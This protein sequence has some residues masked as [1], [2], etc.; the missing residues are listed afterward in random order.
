M[1]ITQALLMNTLQCLILSIF[2]YKVLGLRERFK[3]FHVLSF[4]A[5]ITLLTYFSFLYYGEVRWGP[6]HGFLILLLM[7]FIFYKGKIG[8]K[9]LFLLLGAILQFFVE[10]MLMLLDEIASIF[11]YIGDIY[12]WVLQTLYCFVLLAYVFADKKIRK[13]VLLRHHMILVLIICIITVL[14]VITGMIYDEGAVHILVYELLLYIIWGVVMTL[15]YFQGKYFAKESEMITL[16][17]QTKMDEQYE[18]DRER[19]NEMIRVL[20]HDLKHHLQI[21]KLKSEEAGDQETIKDIELYSGYLKKYDLI[22]VNNK[23]ANAIIN[24][25]HYECLKEQ[26]TFTV[27]GNFYDDLELSKM[28]LTALL[29]NLL[30]NAFEAALK[31]KEP[32]LRKIDLSINRDKHFLIIKLENGC[33]EKPKSENG[34]YI[35]GKPDKIKHGLGIISIEQVIN[36]YNGLI[37]SNYHDGLFC[38]SI[39]FRA[40]TA[41]EGDKES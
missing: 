41:S 19:A 38:V 4:I 6:L 32:D 40:Y 1:S 14:T 35:T 28:K 36:E 39:I 23:T 18:L 16:A 8:E 5:A 2:F 22:E 27:K 29:G 9:I 13:Y 12:Y 24:Y 3:W 15:F 26:V 17:Y 25:H 34:N 30:E 33:A 21:W 10:D 20:S 7:L 31:V 11:N 37:E